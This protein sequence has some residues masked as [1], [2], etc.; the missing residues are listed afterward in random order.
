MRGNRCAISGAENALVREQAVAGGGQVGSVGDFVSAADV[1]DSKLAEIEANGT[2]TASEKVKHFI[3]AVVV[4]EALY[5][6]AGESLGQAIVRAVV[7]AA[8]KNGSL[9]EINPARL[10]ARHSSQEDI[11]VFDAK[12]SP[13]V[14]KV[15]SAVVEVIG[16]LRLKGCT[17]TKC[18]ANEVFQQIVN[19]SLFMLKGQKIPVKG[20]SRVDNEARKIL[21]DVEDTLADPTKITA[22]DMGRVIDLTNDG[23]AGSVAVKGV[24][25]KSAKTYRLDFLDAG[26]SI[27]ET[28]GLEKQ[29]EPKPKPKPKPKRKRI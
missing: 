10:V 29:P 13:D 15:E 9:H 18:R 1:L 5:I 12:Q 25:S 21:K 8:W 17:V 14:A 7:M 20:R 27:S 28:L 11:V 3:D 2:M 19:F 22:K 6:K 4:A 24:P 23:L 16:M 26:G